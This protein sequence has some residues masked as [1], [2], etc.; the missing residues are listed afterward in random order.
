MLYGV[1]LNTEEVWIHSVGEEC[2]KA[3]RPL[4]YFPET[5]MMNKYDYVTQFLDA[6]MNTRNHRAYVYR[7]K[8]EVLYL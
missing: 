3:L 6:G 7:S 5:V 8:T 4:L 1:G 2:M